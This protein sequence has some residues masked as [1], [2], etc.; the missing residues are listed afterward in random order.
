MRSR[1][2]G[3]FDIKDARDII[4]S[5]TVVIRSPMQLQILDKLLG[6]YNKSFYG[7]Y[8]DRASKGRFA[9]AT[10]VVLACSA[11]AKRKISM[12]KVP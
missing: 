4:L 6:E 11:C 12:D 2:V 9:L 1:L 8:M 7:L 10:C 3:H 5:S